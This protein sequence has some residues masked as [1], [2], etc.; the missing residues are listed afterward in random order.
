MSAL[1]VKERERHDLKRA[2]V[3]QFP[4]GQGVSWGVAVGMDSGEWKRT[5]INDRMS[6]RRLHDKG[7]GVGCSERRGEGG[8]HEEVGEM[9]RSRQCLAMAMVLR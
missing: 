4:M 3:W 2:V 7:L 9:E 1:S 8:V 5:D 6:V